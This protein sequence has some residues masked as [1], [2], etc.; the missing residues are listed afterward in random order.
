MIPTDADP[1][2]HIYAFDVESGDLLWKKAMDRGV[3]TTPVLIDGRV[4]AVSA[5]GEVVALDAKTGKTLW[6][7]TPFGRLKP[8][9]FVQA[10]AHAGKRLFVVD[11][12]NQILALDSET[13][14]TEWKT[15]LGARANTSVAVFGDTVIVGTD[16]AHLNWIDA[17]S[18]RLEKRVQLKEGRPYGTL[19]LAPPLLF[20]LAAGATGSIIALDAE[21]GAVRWKQE[22]AKEWTT[23]RPLVAGA[24]VIVGSDAK[25]LCAF[26]RRTGSK[27]WCRSVSHV[28]RGLGASDD[29]WLYVGSLSG[30]VQA[31]RLDAADPP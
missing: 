14:A 19:I 29:G 11:N 20:A 7:E 6:T 22:T 26:D 1:R 23:Y 18:G 27:Q 24:S 15:P 2:G 25:E 12:T 10:P 28:P 9:P 21:S 3:A 4:T 13:G 5:L 31:Y 17:A 16:D 30:V 8:I